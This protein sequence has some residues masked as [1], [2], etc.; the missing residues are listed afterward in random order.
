MRAPRRKRPLVRELADPPTGINLEDISRRIAYVGSPEHKQS[1]SFAGAPRPRADATLCDPSFS[2]QQALIQSWLQEAI[3]NGCCGAPW[4]GD[5]PR[6]VWYKSGGI[7][8]EARLINSDQ[9]QY[10]GW[11]LAPDEW[12]ARIGEFYD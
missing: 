6:Y 3:C 8:Y 2:S 9:G 10:K 1:R 12:P 4:E 5:F 11:Q 7:V